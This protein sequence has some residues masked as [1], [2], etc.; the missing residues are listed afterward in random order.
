MCT[1]N[2]SETAFQLKKIHDTLKNREDLNIFK[3]PRIKAKLCKHVQ[4]LEN[5]DQHECESTYHYAVNEVVIERSDVTMIKLDVF[6]NDE[7]ATTISADGLIVA[8]ST[9]SSAY[10]LSLGGS[11][12]HPDVHCMILNAIAP[13]SISNRP[14]ILPNQTKI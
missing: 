14:L 3:M 8:S 13:M 5:L 10:N 1:F 9:G 2:I 11:L 6:L 4:T 12:V 7:Y